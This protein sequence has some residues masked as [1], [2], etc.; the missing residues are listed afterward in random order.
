M[1]FD[2]FSV[3]LSLSDNFLW[4]IHFRVDGV[5]NLSL[6]TDLVLGILYRIR[7]GKS[8]SSQE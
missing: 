3:K 8:E 4:F 1:A 5:T 6:I 7:F 2:L